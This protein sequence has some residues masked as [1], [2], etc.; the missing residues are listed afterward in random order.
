[1]GAENTP[2][3]EVALQAVMGTPPLTV[4][5][6]CRGSAGPATVTLCPSAS[7]QEEGVKAR[8]EGRK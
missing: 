6:G 7:P 2:G 5:G 3:V 4:A 1:M 8:V